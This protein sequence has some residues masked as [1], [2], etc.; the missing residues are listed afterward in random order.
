[1]FWYSLSLSALSLSLSLS[2]SLFLFLS[3]FLVLFY[4]S[5]FY[6]LLCLHL[7][8]HT[9]IF[10]VVVIWLQFYT[11]WVLVIMVRFG[12]ELHFNREAAM[13]MRGSKKD[14]FECGAMER[15]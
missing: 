1:M 8:Y 4:F 6:A 3:F 5:S 14:G 9:Y 13:K 7:H 11:Q 2:L 15:F 12:Q 10:R